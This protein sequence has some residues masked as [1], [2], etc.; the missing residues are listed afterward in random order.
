M[1]KRGMVNFMIILGLVFSLFA[2]AGE[3]LAEDL[4]TAPPPDFGQL[5][6]A[7]GTSSSAGVGELAAA[8]PW[9]TTSASL[10][11][12]PCE[13]PWCRDTPGQCSSCTSNAQCKLQCT[14]FSTGI[15]SAGRCICAC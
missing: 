15:C 12:H 7:P 4:P 5:L 1:K 8:F 11:S 3:A 6:C 10:S 2:F 9:L 13:D 14:Q